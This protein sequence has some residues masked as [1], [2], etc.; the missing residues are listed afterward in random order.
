MYMRCCESGC[1][2]TRFADVT[3]GEREGMGA[4]AL[5]APGRCGLDECALSASYRQSRHEVS[6]VVSFPFLVLPSLVC[7]VASFS[8]VFCPPVGS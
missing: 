1:P 5:A 3:L 2:E 7:V 6:I 4:G 8:L